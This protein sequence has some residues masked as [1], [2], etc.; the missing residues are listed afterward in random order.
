[1]AG[2]KVK[3]FRENHQTPKFYTPDEIK[4]MLD[5]CTGELECYRPMIEF[6]LLTACRTGEML[7]LKW[8][9]VDFEGSRIHFRNTKTAQDRFVEMGIELRRLLVRLP[10]LAGCPWVFPNLATKEPY[11]Y[12]SKAKGQYKPQFP[13][14]AWQKIVKRA[15]LIDR[16]AIP[17]ALRHTAATVIARDHSLNEAKAILGHSDL[18]TTLRYAQVASDAFSRAATLLEDLLKQAAHA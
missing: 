18:K 12:P 6:Q 15:G 17:Y 16:G 5:A 8:E 9:D 13:R 7:L 3:L 4:R 1:M 11:G 14:K 2:G 10:R